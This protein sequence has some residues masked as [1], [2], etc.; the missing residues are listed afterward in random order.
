MSDIGPGDWVEC[1]R[2]ADV[3][4]PG[5]LRGAVTAG[6]VYRVERIFRVEGRCGVCRDHPGTVLVL[7]QTAESGAG[8]CPCS[9]RPLYRPKEQLLRDLME[10]VP[11]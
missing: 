11:A 9:F 4:T 6:A 7:G 5:G 2:S 3:L 1:I 8:W 10:P